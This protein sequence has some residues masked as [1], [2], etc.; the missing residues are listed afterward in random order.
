M[1]GF[2]SILFLGRATKSQ[3]VMMEA[4]RPRTKSLTW[5]DIPKEELELISVPDV[6]EDVERRARRVKSSSSA[7][8]RVHRGN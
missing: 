3:A 5:S 1:A 6:V 7:S 4:F 2:S 8:E